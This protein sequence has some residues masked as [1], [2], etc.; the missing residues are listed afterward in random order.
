MDFAE[1]LIMNRS[2]SF[3]MCLI[4]FLIGAFKPSPLFLVSIISIFKRFPCWRSGWDICALRP[5]SENQKS[6]S[7]L[8]VRTVAVFFKIDCCSASLKFVVSLIP[9]RSF[10]PARF[11]L[12]FSIFFNL[13]TCEQ[14][15]SQREVR[16]T[17]LLS[18]PATLSIP[19]YQLFPSSLK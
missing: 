16:C 3:F 5:Y 13:C 15:E 4:F 14:Y 17:W 10:H 6:K 1:W 18:L 8:W 7:Y 11:K 19:T 2:N 9:F 12:L